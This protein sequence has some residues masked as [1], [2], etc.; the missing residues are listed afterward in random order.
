MGKNE[1]NW[2]LQDIVIHSWLYSS[3]FKLILVNRFCEMRFPMHTALKES[4]RGR[5]N[6]IEISNAF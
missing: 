6:Q 5:M 3:P 2:D 1:S 4:K